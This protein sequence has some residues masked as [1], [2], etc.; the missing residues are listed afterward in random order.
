M[1]QAAMVSAA[2]SGY[3]PEAQ[4]ENC[5]MGLI[6]RRPTFQISAQPRQPSAGNSLPDRQ[7]KRGGEIS[8][9]NAQA[10]RPAA[11]SQKTD[12]ATV[13]DQGRRFRVL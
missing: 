5:W 7:R 2:W 13:H 9:V 8:W 3:P 11:S 4:T 1:Q 12:A 10:N 6:V